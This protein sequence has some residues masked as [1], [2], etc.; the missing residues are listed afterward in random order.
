MSDRLRAFSC[1]RVRAVN[2]DSREELPR[3]R[4]WLLGW[5]HIAA[6]RDPKLRTT[7]RSMA[8]ELFS[9]ALPDYF[10]QQRRSRVT[11]EPRLISKRPGQPPSGGK[12]LQP[13]T[14]LDRQRPTVP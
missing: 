5:R 10:C 1:A 4:L 9:E 3:N 7:R 14:F 2:A 11:D 8:E 6:L 13:K 12:T